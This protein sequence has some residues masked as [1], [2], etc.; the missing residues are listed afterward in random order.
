MEVKYEKK[1]SYGR[2][3]YY[4]LNAKFQ[5]NYALLTGLSTLTKENMKLLEEM[6]FK[7]KLVDKP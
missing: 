3:R 5:K 4:I 6:G 7:F 2:D 1:R